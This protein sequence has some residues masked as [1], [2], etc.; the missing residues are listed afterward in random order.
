MKVSEKKFVPQNEAARRRLIEIIEE[1]EQTALIYKGFD[2]DAE[3]ENPVFRR[4]VAAGVPVVSAY[5]LIHRDE[6]NTILV[7]KA[8]RQAEK[9]ISGAILS[10]ARVKEN[11]AS[12]AAAAVSTF[13]PKNMT[14]EERKNIRERV[15]RGENVIF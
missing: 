12:P 7:E 8:V 5:E 15:R 13:D 6:V 9:R 14:K 10:G 4:L 2:L 11:G 3:F 1:A